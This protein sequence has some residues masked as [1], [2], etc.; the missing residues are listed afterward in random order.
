GMLSYQ[1]S[2]LLQ[3][4]QADLSLSTF[5]LDVITGRVLPDLFLPHLAGARRGSP[6]RSVARPDDAGLTTA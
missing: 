4:K 1:D 5:V 2:C 6:S 3:D